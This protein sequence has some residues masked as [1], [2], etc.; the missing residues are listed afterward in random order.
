L[1]AE[2]DYC[3]PLGIP[4]SVFLGWSDAD[5]GY[6]LAW[7]ANKRATCSGCGTRADEW[8]EDGDAYISDHYTCQG[9]AR[10]AEEQASNLDRGPDDTPRPGQHAFL[11]PRELYDPAAHAQPPEPDQ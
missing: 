11:T 10:L 5:R 1:R 4:H 6:A 3:V 2:L 8:A 7:Q 9:C